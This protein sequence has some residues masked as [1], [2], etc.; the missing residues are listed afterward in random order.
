MSTSFGRT[1]F[2]GASSYNTD[3]GMRD[4]VEDARRRVFTR[5]NRSIPL[6]QQITQ[7]AASSFVDA[8][9]IRAWVSAA[10]PADVIKNGD[11]LGTKPLR[12]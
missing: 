3:F 8:G 10:V 7:L 12:P 5:Y 9:T 11:G 6:E 2:Y 4:P 1:G